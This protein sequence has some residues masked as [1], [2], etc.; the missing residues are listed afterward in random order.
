M[1]SSSNHPKSSGRLH[2]HSKTTIFCD[3]ACKVPSDIDEN[4]L[5]SMVPAAAA[6]A[7]LSRANHSLKIREKISGLSMCSAS[8]S[9]H[10]GAIF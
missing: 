4:Q 8:V 10:C 6:A 5:L 2:S 1:T 3:S 9:G 7:A